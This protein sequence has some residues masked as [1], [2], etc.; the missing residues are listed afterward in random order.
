MTKLKPF[1]EKVRQSVQN[2]LN[3][4]LVKR[5]FLEN[6]FQAPLSS[7]TNVLS[8]WKWYFLVFWKLL[9]QEVMKVRQSFKNCLNQ[10]LI[11]GSFLENGFE[12]PLSSKTN[13]LSVWK[14]HFSLFCKFL[15][16]Q[17][18]TIFWESEANRSKLVTSKFGHN[19]IVRKLF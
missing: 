14:G 17:V 3:Q 1:S 11:I 9:S 16:D 4:N 15:S 7:K 18:E 10:N 6:G 12:A 8:V 13:L 5:R 19:H 2:Y